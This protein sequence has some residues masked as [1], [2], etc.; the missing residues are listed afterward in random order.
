MKLDEWNFV[1]E[2]Y[3]W[4]RQNWKLTY[5]EPKY[6]QQEAMRYRPS[7]KPI[8]LRKDFKERG[9]QVI[10]NLANTHLTPEQATYQEGI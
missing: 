3:E 1:D 9:L 4:K 2:N 5:R 10:F 6:I 8:N 7:A